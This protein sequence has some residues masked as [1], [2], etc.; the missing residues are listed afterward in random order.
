MCCG[1]V[2]QK[3]HLMAPGQARPARPI[4][5][6]GPSPTSGNEELPGADLSRKRRPDLTFRPRQDPTRPTGIHPPCKPRNRPEVHFTPSHAHGR[7]NQTR[8]PSLGDLEWERPPNVKGSVGWGVGGVGGGWVLAA[9][10]SVIT[11]APGHR[12]SSRIED[13]AANCTRS[14]SLPTSHTRY[15]SRPAP[16]ANGLDVLRDE[17]E[18]RKPR[19]HPSD[20]IRAT[21]DVGG[22]LSKQGVM[23]LGCAVVRGL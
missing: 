20:H 21:I 10:R 16:A 15:G 22:D 1:W 14:A 2:R 3:T 7:P 13:R 4:E 19:T 5:C 9:W 17:A 12:R 11:L 8:R 18:S 6:G 23:S